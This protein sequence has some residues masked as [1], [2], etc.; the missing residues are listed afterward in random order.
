VAEK[1]T[2]RR[3]VEAGTKIAQIGYAGAEDTEPEQLVDEAQQLIFSVGRENT[4]N[5]YGPIADVLDDTLEERDLMTQNGGLA[6]GV[7]T[8]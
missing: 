1:A 4:K 8:G 5:D 7:P 6:Q 3:L 2:I